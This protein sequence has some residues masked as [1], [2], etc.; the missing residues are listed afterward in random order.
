[1]WV[2]NWPWSN[3]PVEAIYRYVHV[4]DVHIHPGDFDNDGQVNNDDL[5]TWE[6]GFDMPSNAAPANGDADYDGDVDGWDFLMWQREYGTVV[7][8][9]L[10]SITPEPTTSALALAA[11]LFFVGRRR[12][13]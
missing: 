1:M 8:L 4:A 12:G 11:T 7:P 6:Q 10:E 5:L 3:F 9:S 2:S 13:R